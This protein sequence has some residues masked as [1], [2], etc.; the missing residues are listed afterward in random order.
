MQALYQ[1]YFPGQ[2]FQSAD[3]WDNVGEA[4]KPADYSSTIEIPDSFVVGRFLSS[5]VLHVAGLIGVT[6]D[7][8]A[9]ES[10]RR[11]DNFH[12]QLV[13]AM[14]SRWGVR[15]EYIPDSHDNALE[16]IESGQA[17]M[18]VGIAP[19][20]NFDHQV[21]FSDQYL[22][23]GLRL[24]IR[25]EDAGEIR[26]FGD[27]SGSLIVTATNEPDTISYARSIAEKGNWRVDFSQQLESDLAFVLLGGNEEV[28]ADAVFADSFKLVPLV[29]NDPANLALTRSDADMP[30][31][32]APTQ[33]QDQDFGYQ[34]MTLALPRND[35][36]FRLLVELTLQ[37]M[38]RDGTLQELLTSVILEEDI[39]VF[40]I[41]PGP[42]TYLSFSLGG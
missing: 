11:L 6:A 16:L 24:M 20:W 32:Y 31:W 36:D 19:D 40:E 5:P 38:A 41:W 27:L 10:Q 30:R 21:D 17:D 7:S 34:M 18:S 3:I 22:R 12:R 37:E 14:A 35:V 4:P 28:D 8:Q 23:H 39:P 26:G 2:T 29:Q 33:R 9:T 25:Q 15:V 13:E 1:T 42:S